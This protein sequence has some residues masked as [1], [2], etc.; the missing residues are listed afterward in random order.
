MST[1]ASSSATP[2]QR[3]VNTVSIGTNALPSASSNSATGVVGSGIGG[4]GVGG[5]EQGGAST[6]SQVNGGGVAGGVS[7]GGGL[8]NGRTIISGLSQDSSKM[9][10]AE[11]LARFHPK[12]ITAQIVALQCFQYLTQSIF[13]EIN[14][15]FMN[16]PPSVDRIFTDKYIH[17]WRREGWADC[18]VILLSALT[19]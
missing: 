7:G 6:T 12:M 15:M 5:V 14:Y 13:I 4:V 19:G 16:I 17:I 8:K 18:F 3:R 2:E 11:A 10:K 9:R 1:R